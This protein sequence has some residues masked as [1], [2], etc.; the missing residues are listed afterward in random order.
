M[1]LNKQMQDLLI[2]AGLSQTQAHIYLFLLKQ[3]VS[4]IW[5]IVNATKISKS[6]VYRD[7]LYLEELR[8][9]KRDVDVIK[10]LSLKGLISGLMNDERKIGKTVNRL[11]SIAPYVRVPME[12]VDEF[13]PLYNVA[14][15]QE[16]YLFMSEVKCT[17]N[18]DMGDFEPYIK[19]IGGL[20]VAKKFLQNRIKHA[21]NHAIVSWQGPVTS[22]FCTER[23]KK[24]FNSEVDMLKSIDFGGTFTILSD[25]SDHV[26]VNRVHNGELSAVLIKSKMMADFQRCQFDNFSRMIG[27]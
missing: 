6:V 8:M 9:V 17:T 3:P 26:L 11:R 19:L 27:K 21:R 22:Y 7:I 20:E 12:E 2:Q 18:L 15:I 24:E 13:T 4:S 23:A 16:A 25:T 10:A 5:Q 14:D 1:A